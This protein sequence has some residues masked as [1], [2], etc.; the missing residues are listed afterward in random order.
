MSQ[1]GDCWLVNHY[2][3]KEDEEESHAQ[4][5][6]QNGV[7]ILSYSRQL[8]LEYCDKCGNND[9]EFLMG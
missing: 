5:A 4:K 1:V 6:T 2:P 9:S 8:M 3:Q 7:F